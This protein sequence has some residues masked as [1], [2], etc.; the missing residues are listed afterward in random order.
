MHRHLFIAGAQR[1]GT[2]YLYRMLEQHPDIAMARPLRPE[3]KFFIRDELYAKGIDYYRRAYFDADAAWLGEKSTSY[4]EHP[5]AAE[6]IARHFPEALVIFMLRDPVERAISNYRFS[7]ENGLETLPFEEALEAE[8]ARS[9]ESGH[10]GISVS[11]YAYAARGH[12]IRYLDAWGERFPQSQL[13]PLVSESVLG[14]EPALRAIFA[15]LGV[16]PDVPLMDT[17]AAVNRSL[18]GGDVP[19]TTRA[20]LR[21]VFRPSN[22]A[23]VGRFGLD[24]DAWL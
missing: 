3:P 1:S 16:D 5:V 7:V 15:R 22:L 18:A 9:G 11:P 23:L 20:S 24:I 12:Y 14:S 21:D 19:E 13:L 4:I 2:T 6:R 10:R 8:S 17:G